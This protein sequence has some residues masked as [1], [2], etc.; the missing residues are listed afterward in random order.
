MSQQQKSCKRSWVMVRQY[1]IQQSLQSGFL[2]ET[3]FV[4]DGNVKKI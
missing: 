1:G 3:R 2:R 4:K